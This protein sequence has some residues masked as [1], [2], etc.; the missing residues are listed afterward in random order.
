MPIFIVFV[1]LAIKVCFNFK[2]CMIVLK[3]L[4]FKAIL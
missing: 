4:N 2:E 1:E 3:Y